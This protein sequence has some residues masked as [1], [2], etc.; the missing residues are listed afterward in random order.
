MNEM[1]GIHAPCGLGSE[2]RRSRET[3]VDLDDVVLLVVRIEAVPGVFKQQE[4]TV[5]LTTGAMVVLSI[6][7]RKDAWKHTEN[8]ERNKAME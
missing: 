5:S 4:V 3:R 7:N 1:S 8:N 6:Q 2:C